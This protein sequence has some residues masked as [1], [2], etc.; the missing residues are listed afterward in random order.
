MDEL[1]ITCT[2]CQE[3]TE[4]GIRCDNCDEVVCPECHVDDG[5][6][7]LCLKCKANEDEDQD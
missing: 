5:V 6:G 4:A 1:A 7:R 2:L 3:E